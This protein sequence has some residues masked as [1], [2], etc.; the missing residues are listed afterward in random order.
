MTHGFDFGSGD[1][2]V[3][4][5]AIAAMMFG[6]SLQ[7]TGADFRRLL[8]RP[9]APLAGMAAQFLLLPLATFLLTLVLPI[10]A[11]YKLGMML[12]AACPGGA[13]SNILTWIARGSLPVSIT[14]TAASSALATVLTPLN[15][16]LYSSLNPATRELMTRISLDPFSLLALIALVLALP[17]AL[18]M[19]AGKRFP[20]FAQRS[21]PWFRNGS[22]LAFLMFISVAL[23]RNLS[24]F[25]EVAPAVLSLV[26]LHNGVA[27]LTGYSLARLLRLGGAETRAVT[28]EIGIQNSGLALLIL[29][30]FYPQAGGMVLVAAMWGLWHLVSGLSLAQFWGWRHR[31]DPQ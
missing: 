20:R 10:D 15:F 23:S 22:L 6:A 3:M 8:T 18:G 5:I 7:L 4:N 24:L 13:F 30:T 21:E 12:V 19:L 1:L 31:H 25:L 2:V 26:V 27:L 17:L 29:F 16:A 14:M 9:K 28:L 11:E